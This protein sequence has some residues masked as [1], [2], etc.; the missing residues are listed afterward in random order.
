MEKLIGVLIALFVGFMLLAG[1]VASIPF[2]APGIGVHFT[3]VLIILSYRAQRVL[4]PDLLARILNPQWDETSSTVRWSINS[5]ALQHQSRAILFSFL[6][7]VPGVILLALQLPGLFAQPR[8]DGLDEFFRKAAGCI[9]AFGGTGLAV[10]ASQNWT[11]KACKKAVRDVVDEYSAASEQFK[12]LK[13]I[14]S[15]IRSLAEE[16]GVSWPPGLSEDIR[17]YIEREKQSLLLDGAG[18][19]QRVATALD[20]ARADARMLESAKERHK[21]TLSDFRVAARQANRAGAMTLV[22]ELE[23]MHQAMTSDAMMSLLIDRR[24]SEFEAIHRDM[25]A[26]LNRIVK[27]AEQ[28]Q[29]TDNA[30]RSPA[31][32]ALQKAFRVLGIREDMSRDAMKKRYKQ[33]AADYHPDRAEQTTAA[34]RMLA[35]ERFKEI[36]VAWRTVEREMSIT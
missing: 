20:S 8:L 28:Y 10:A 11:V 26:D 4:Q 22:E 36:N 7:V 24:F 34:I 33:L 23:A 29:A 35:E 3:C 31:E 5:S 13:E 30:A 32:S 2:W 15:E 6:A 25:A 1:A 16:I 19:R 9:M 18:F 27:Q 12:A 21:L 17:A 14:E